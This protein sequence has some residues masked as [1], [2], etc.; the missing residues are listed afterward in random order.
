M[1]TLSKLLL[2]AAPGAAV[3]LLSSS[4]LAQLDL[5]PPLPNVLLLMDTSGSMERT[6]AGNEPTCSPLG[7]APPELERSRWT[8]L[9]EAL[10]GPIQGFS[11][12]AQPRTDAAQFTAQ[13]TYGGAQP[14]DR[15][16]YIRYHRPL[17][18]PD[19]CTK[20]PRGGSIVQHRYTDYNQACATAWSQLDTGFLDNAKDLVRFSLMTFDTVTHAGTGSGGPADGMAG[21]WSYYLGYQS[22]AGSAL[23][24]PPGC[25]T[26]QTFE[27]G[28]R[29]PLAPDW[30]GPLVPFHPDP[31]A[32]PN[33][34]RAIADRIQ[35]A[36]ISMRPYGA[37]PLAGMLTDARTYLTQD[38]STLNMPATIY[39]GKE[40]GP[41]ND[42][43]IVNGVRQQ[44]IIL[45]SDGEPNMDLRDPNPA[46]DCA[47]APGPGP[48]GTGCPFQQPWDIAE[49]L[50][51]N[52][53]V[54]TY[55]IGYALSTP[56][57]ID[58]DAL[59]ENDFLPG[60]QCENPA[61]S[62]I[63]A[64]CTLTRIAVEGGT[65][66]GYFPDNIAELNSA[67]SQIFME[68]ARPTSRTVPVFA[69][70]STPGGGGA[71]AAGYQ[72]SA[73]FNPQPPPGS[74][75]IWSGNLERKRYVCETV[76]GQLTAVLKDVEV[77][78][79]DS[80]GDNMQA[81]A[82]TPRRFFTAFGELDSGTNTIHSTRSIR[83]TLG[84]TDGLG[85]Y[86]GTMT[87]GGA[88]V[89]KT[90]F[91]AEAAFTPRAFGLDP[92]A[93][94]LPAACASMNA[95][96]AADCAQEAVK[97]QLGDNVNGAQ[98]AGLLGAIYH[99]T[100]VLMGPPRDLITDD[101][102]EN[103]A[104]A[105][106]SRPLTLFTATVD[107][108]LH[109]F[110]VE[111][112]SQQQN[113]LWSF[114]P[115]A[116]LPRVV[117]TFNQQAQL[118]DGA[119]VVRN[120][121]LDQTITQAIDA[122]SSWRTVLVASGG[123][124]GSFYYALDVTNPTAPQFLWQLSTDDAGNPLFGDSPPTP[125]ITTVRV[126]ETGNMADTREIAVAILAGGEASLAAG[127]CA[128]QSPSSPLIPV[129]SSY[130]PRAQ[131]RCWGGAPG[132]V[133][134][135]RS[136][137]IVRLDNGRVLRSFRGD[138]AEAPP[139]LVAAG[140]V[141]QAPFDS[142]L[143]GVPVPFPALPGQI[144]DRVYIGD[145]DGTLWRVDLTSADPDDWNANIAW[146]AYSLAGDNGSI[147][148]PIATPP[149]VSVDEV[150]NAVLLF[151]TGEQE[152]LS[153]SPGMSTRLW[154]ITER[155]GSVAGAP[156]YQL[157]DNWYKTFADGERVTGPLSLFNSSLYFATYQPDLG[158][159]NTCV[160]GRGSVWGKHYITGAP[161]LPDSANPGAFIEFEEQPI[162]TVVF[163][164]AV[165]QTP[166]CTETTLYNDPVF[167]AFL[168]AS[169][170]SGA[171]YQLVY[172]T[173]SVEGGNTISQG[174]GKL[175]VSTINLPPPAS[176][177]RIDS[178]A[179]VVD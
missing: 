95:L 43:C 130:Q 79:G 58:C 91:A 94:L 87:G 44:Y 9:V 178:W 132:A 13:Y 52:H 67:L 113:E 8:N 76:S 56:A 10:T 138:L 169:A 34:L 156:Q 157:E 167:G 179:S 84:I 129:T 7:A 27:V 48:E 99:S 153:A 108:Q 57:G 4:A 30:E 50:N 68:I 143:T 96:S 20:G 15:N 80:F 176:G 90:G 25:A 11:C 41:K 109:A 147:G 163:G 6:V 26:P 60:G 35:D 33:E 22:G 55:T 92:G 124:G 131:V 81:S 38:V 63:R 172:H 104:A 65:Q 150:G 146:D 136:L 170:S 3:W 1:R 12:Y 23:G 17:S 168:E 29:N 77:D 152:S 123:V 51:L 141:T 66:R 69:S 160:S 74:S 139:G 144:A 62:A 118:L 59:G 97:W 116:V 101:S 45:L 175:P 78:E 64:C 42:P 117:A 162:N 21:M 111:P 174:E 36:L 5:A 126:T 106:A 70:S 107:G 88:I 14:Y 120:V 151:A 166:N 115:P 103:F 137:T 171:S 119:P 54:T 2:T 16:Y 28:S 134:P 127:T 145:A 177:L 39:D 154:S 149:V 128:R 114:F 105:N 112:D 49:D 142:P 19:G 165:V 89:D 83:P 82:P 32:P 102:Y 140:R 121:I 46:K 159:A 135:G 71:N 133:G 148:Q 72:F 53:R 110:R 158:A 93:G 31:F 75:P 86:T 164:V 100:P 173:G 40:L 125:A 24:Q 85:T 37:T 18:G 61:S 161:A 122:S 47:S 98:R 73:S 155:L